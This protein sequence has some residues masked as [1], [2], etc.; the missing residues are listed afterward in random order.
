MIKDDYLTIRK[1][2]PN[3]I[4]DEKPIRHLTTWVPISHL[5][6]EYFDE[7][8]LY[9]IDGKLEKSTKL[10]KLLQMWKEVDLLG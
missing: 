6:V 3:F 4:L 8:C 1:W 9:A 10:T 5:N 7:E 2:V